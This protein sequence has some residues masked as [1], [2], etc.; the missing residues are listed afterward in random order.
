MDM[1]ANNVSYLA[2]QLFFTAVNACETQVD[3]TCAS[4]V[5]NYTQWFLVSA[6]SVI[7]L[8]LDN[9]FMQ[10]LRLS[11]AML[12]GCKCFGKKKQKHVL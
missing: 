8:E 6:V 3:A 7:L 11:Q 2:M 1:V 9:H 12:C 5:G 10:K 4:E